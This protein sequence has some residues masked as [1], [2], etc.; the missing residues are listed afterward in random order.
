MLKIR[1]DKKVLVVD[2][3]VDYA[4]SIGNVLSKAGANLQIAHNTK[5][6]LELLRKF[7]PEVVIIDIRLDGRNGIDGGL[8][9]IKEFRNIIPELFC[10]VATSY[11]DSRLG[12]ESYQ[13]GIN[14]LLIKPC[15]P[16][17]ILYA[18]AKGIETLENRYKLNLLKKLVKE[19]QK[20]DPISI[21]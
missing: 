6:A 5:N 20:L 9:L 14:Y 11:P 7:K 1:D 4:N 19:T 18:V 16:E 17:R 8:S 21:N 12:E 15:S 2:A 10:I 13:L 3:D